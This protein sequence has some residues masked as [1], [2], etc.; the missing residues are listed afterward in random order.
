MERIGFIGG[1]NTN[2]QNIQGEKSNT[3]AALQGAGAGIALNAAVDTVNIGYKSHQLVKQNK[4]QNVNVKFTDAV[5]NV[6]NKF[7]EFG[8]A[9]VKDGQVE[10]RIMTVFDKPI[11]GKHLI[12][13]GAVLSAGVGAG[14]GVLINKKE[15][16]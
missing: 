16:E 6:W 15:N 2:S 1:I 14:A 7:K 13:A 11:K 5:K 10:S 4:E 3:V 12:A 8:N 9:K